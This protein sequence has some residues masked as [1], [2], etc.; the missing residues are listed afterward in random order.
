MELKSKTSGI[1]GNVSITKYSSI[2]GDIIEKIYIPNLVVAVGR[3]Y[4]ASRMIGTTST[5]M[6]H[7]ALGANST[8]AVNGDATLGT[9]LGRA[10]LTSSTSLD[11]V[12]TYTATFGA[13]VAT[14]SVQEAGIFN[15]TSG[16]IM[17][18]RTTFAVVNKGVSDILAVAW[19][20]SVL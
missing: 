12:V 7:I 16:G 1:I 19:T 20:I 8:A 5:V 10:V 18:A 17:L 11:N 3:T 2:T 9:E 15:A 4:I 13:G 6:T 14:G